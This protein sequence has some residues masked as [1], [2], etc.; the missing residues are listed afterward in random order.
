[1][2]KL[3]INTVFKK[4][5]EGL[6]LPIIQPHQGAFSRLC[7]STIFS[8]SVA[9]NLYTLLCKHQQLTFM[10]PSFFNPPIQKSNKATHSNQLKG[11]P[12]LNPP[13]ILKQILAVLPSNARGAAE[14]SERKCTY[15]MTKEE[16]STHQTANPIYGHSPLTS[17]SLP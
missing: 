16:W 5:L 6:D 1:M 4:W 13:K 3:P 9:N 14:K 17:K 7:T 11:I 2:W 12:C 10:Q 15:G 8:H